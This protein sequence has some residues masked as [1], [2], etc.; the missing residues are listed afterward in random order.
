[1][2]TSSPRIMVINSNGSM[3]LGLV[4]AVLETLGFIQFPF[5]KRGLSKV[6]QCQVGTKKYAEARKSF[7]SEFSAQVSE[8]VYGSNLGGRTQLDKA[9]SPISFFRHKDTLS[10]PGDSAN[11]FLLSVW[12]CYQWLNENNLYKPVISDPKGFLIFNNL[13]NQKYASNLLMEKYFKLHFGNNVSFVYLDRCFAGW[14][15]SICSQTVFKPRVRTREYFMLAHRRLD[16][17]CKYREFSNSIDNPSV[18]K[19]KFDNFFDEDGS[20]RDSFYWEL[21]DFLQLGE[22]DRELGRTISNV[23]LFGRTFTRE[24]GF[25]RADADHW[26][27]GALIW[28]TLARMESLDSR[29][30]VLGFSVIVSPCIWIIVSVRRLSRKWMLYVSQ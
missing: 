7:F 25:R 4:G 9:K 28:K 3:G 6:L 22:V 19:V 18:L 16:S 27:F 10:F 24:I 29:F 1:M 26:I 12:T 30:L 23:D 11:D 17:L 20:F 2:S 21:C 14:L 8:S 13:P 5:R 15:E